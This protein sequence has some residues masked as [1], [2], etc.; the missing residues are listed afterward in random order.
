MKKSPCDDVMRVEMDF[1]QMFLFQPL[2]EMS[3]CKTPIKNLYLKGASTYPGGVF[4]ASGHSTAQVM[5]KDVEG[6]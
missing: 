6:K 3:A 5:L 4:A 2:P 1:N